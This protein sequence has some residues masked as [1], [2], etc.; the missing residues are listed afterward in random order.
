VLKSAISQPTRSLSRNAR[1]TFSRLISTFGPGRKVSFQGRRGPIRDVGPFLETILL[2]WRESIVLDIRSGRSSIGCFFII[3]SGLSPNTR[4]VS[5]GST[6]F[7]VL[8]R[9]ANEGGFFRPLVKEVVERYLDC[10]NRKCGF[11]LM[12][13]WKFF[14]E[15]R[16]KRSPGSAAPTAG[17]NTS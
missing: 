2:L 8:R 15:D 7:A 14:H 4:S 6:G 9:E 1:V 13:R 5:S 11:A 10:G 3:S 17:Q 16:P 12:E